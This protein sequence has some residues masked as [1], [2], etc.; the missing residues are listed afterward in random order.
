MTLRAETSDEEAGKKDG[1][2]RVPDDP[3][4]PSYP[5]CTVY[6][7][8]S[9]QD[10]VNPSGFRLLLGGTWLSAAKPILT[11]TAKRQARDFHVKTQDRRST[12]L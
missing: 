3:M 12:M 11:D 6:T 7:Q 10:K 4:A 2:A 5:L 8:T 1:G 9:S